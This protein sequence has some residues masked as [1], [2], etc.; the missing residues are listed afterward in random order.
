MATSYLDLTNELLRELNEV[1]LTASNFAS[2]VGVQAHVKDALN[3]AYF[4]IINQEPQWPFLSAGESGTVDPMYGKAY[5]ETVVGQRFYELKPASDSI[6]TDY[7]SI[8]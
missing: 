3:K 7:S 4:D 5:V 8:D 6:T 1:V 2:A